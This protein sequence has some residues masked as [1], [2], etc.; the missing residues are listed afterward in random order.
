MLWRITSTIGLI[1]LMA[2]SGDHVQGTF[3]VN[4]KT[5]LF[6]FV[7]VS[8]AARPEQPSVKY[9]IVLASDAEI[10]EAARTPGPL[11]DLAKQGR[12]HAVRVVWKEG[13]D[14]LTA[15][16]FHNEVAESGQPTV[17]GAIIDLRKY[18][19]RTLGVQI[20]SR[21]V[22]QEWHF[23]AT[24]EATVVPVALTAD[25]L[26][27]AVPIV[28]PTDVERDTRVES[29]DTDPVSMKRTLGRLG[30]AANEEG[31]LQAV[32]DGNLPA[33]RLFLRLGMNASTVSEG[34]PLLMSATLHCVSEP[35]EGRG[36]IIRALL[37]AHAKVDVADD[38][39]STPLLWSVN[40][41]CPPDIVRAFIAAGANVNAR[42]KGGATPLMLAQALNRAEIIKVLQAAGAKP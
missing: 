32:N 24:L 23:N 39:G 16:P 1:L 40:V 41:G 4:G 22:G 8:R 37:A 19:E 28:P 33:V 18:D 7:Y 10:P 26:R 34:M 35:V 6:R 3:T 5:R 30:F 29:D 11:A 21:P 2:P 20:K 25:D 17:G 27:E 31:F 36:D 38:N 9:L 13:T 15:T 12:I 42:A 14:S